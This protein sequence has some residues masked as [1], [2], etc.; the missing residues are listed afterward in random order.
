MQKNRF[1][2]SALAGGVSLFILGFLIYGTFL[3][4]FMNAN[5]GVDSDVLA[6]VYKPMEQMNWSY[7]IISNLAAGLMLACIM[8]WANASSFMAGL[9]MAGLIGLLM[10]ISMDFSFLSFSNLHT[11]KS[12]I[13]DI[14]GGTVLYAISGGVI[15][16]IQSMKK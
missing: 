13:A 5:T 12:S 15:A 10:G 3:M 8:Q 4:D 7:M 14:I 1:I 2:I 9:R 11:M 16:W 6:K